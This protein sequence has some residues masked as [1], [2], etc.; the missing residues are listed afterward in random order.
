MK[1]VY[2]F[3]NKLIDAQILA[4]LPEH[5]TTNIITQQVPDDAKIEDF[6]DGMFL[7]EKYDVRIVKEKTIRYEQLV[8]TKLREK[9]TLDQELAI[10]RQRDSKPEEFASY[11]EYAEECKAKAKDEIGD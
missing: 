2:V 11:F 5:I 7:Q 6:V 9:Y 4:Y 8:I 1:K 3:E 10:L